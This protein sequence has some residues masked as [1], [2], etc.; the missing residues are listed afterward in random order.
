MAW[1]DIV[2]TVCGVILFVSL[3]PQLAHGFKTKTGPIKHV[4]SVPTFLGL[5]I[6]ALVYF[7]LHLYLSFIMVFLTGTIWLLLFIQ[8]MLYGNKK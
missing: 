7:S 6:T 4:T 3:I 8:R 1:Q 2:L 5:Y